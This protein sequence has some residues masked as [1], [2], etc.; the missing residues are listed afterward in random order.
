[1]VLSR[2]QFPA[3]TAS[4]GIIAD[5]VTV[6]SLV[7]EEQQAR[8]GIP[9]HVEIASSF[10]HRRKRLLLLLRDLQGGNGA[11]SGCELFHSYA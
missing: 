7:D 4:D 11:G 6:S 3:T 8:S 1:M 5:Y 10:Y 2:G 9:V